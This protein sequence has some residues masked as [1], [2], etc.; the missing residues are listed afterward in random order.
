MPWRRKR[1]SEPS[2]VR[3]AFEETV[4]RVEEAKRALVAVVPA[5]R[6]PGSPLADSLIAFEHGL[7]VARESMPPWHSDETAAAWERCNEGISEALERA[8]RVRLA[9]PALDY[10]SLV[11]TLGRLIEPLEAFEDADSLL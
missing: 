4:E 9:A 6:A 1:E 10:E 5:G 3:R 2:P 7:R 11:M 8:E